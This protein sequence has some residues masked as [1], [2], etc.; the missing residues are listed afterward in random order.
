[1]SNLPAILTSLSRRYHHLRRYP[2]CR[3]PVLQL[4]K[5][6]QHRWLL[7][8]QR[9]AGGESPGLRRPH[10]Q[11]VCRHRSDLRGE[12]VN[13]PRCDRS[14]EL[15]QRRLPSR[16]FLDQV[17]GFAHQHRQLVYNHCPHQSI[18][19]RSGL[20]HRPYRDTVWI[21][22]ARHNL[23]ELSIFRCLYGKL[24]LATRHGSCECDDQQ[25]RIE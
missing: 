17:R 10:A 23:D 15:L 14:P 7:P 1:M 5:W 25:L 6:L 24:L 2:T 21:R 22:D 11:L 13:L 18:R 16:C 3:R 9:A 12:T 4:G 20:C 8:T 19:N